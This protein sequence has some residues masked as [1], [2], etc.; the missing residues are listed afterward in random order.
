MNLRKDTRR[1]A[2]ET[3][4][5]GE[6]GSCLAICE[7]YEEPLENPSAAGAIRERW[8]DDRLTVMM[9]KH[10]AQSMHFSAL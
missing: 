6:M 5:I 10:K 3:I 7:H 2:S 1:D 8:N 4:D 9:L